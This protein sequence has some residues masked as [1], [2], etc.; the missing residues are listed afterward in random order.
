MSFDQLMT[1]ARFP[2]SQQYDSMWMIDHSMG[3][4][5]V[6]LTESLCEHMDLKPGMRVLDLGCGKAMSSIFLAREFGVTVF[7]TDLWIKPSENQERIGE[8]GV[9]DRVFP[10]YA[11]AHA[12]PYADNFFDAI[13]SVDAYQYFGTSDLY[14]GVYLAKLVKP[15]GQIGIVVPGLNK[16]M[17]LPVPPHFETFWD[18]K[19]C[20]CFHAAD[21]WRAHFEKTQTVDV[22]HCAVI[23]DSWRHWR[24]YEQAK[25]LVDKQMFPD[26][27]V[28]LEADQGEYLTLVEMVARRR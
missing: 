13:V 7:A 21:W 28:T 12:L 17:P 8:A 1:Q 3:P 5:A 20:G 4:N 27:L 14:L 25:K 24:D 18:P 19:E 2:R 16:E 23:E 9:A 15:G 22:E 10:I 26:E 6:W 11:E